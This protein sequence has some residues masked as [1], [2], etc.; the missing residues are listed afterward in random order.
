MNLTTIRTANLIT[1]ELDVSQHYFVRF[2]CLSGIAEPPRPTLEACL[3]ASETSQTETAPDIWRQEV[4]NDEFSEC[5]V[6]RRYT[7]Y[8]NLKKRNAKYQYLQEDRKG[9]AS[10]SPCFAFATSNSDS[11]FALPVFRSPLA[12][13]IGALKVVLW[14]NF[15]QLFKKELAWYQRQG[16]RFQWIAFYVEIPTELPASCNGKYSPSSNTQ[17]HLPF[18]FRYAKSN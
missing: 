13:L 17:I 18:F 7:Y 16:Y 8:K 1:I 5:G 6:E 14:G 11:P 4:I 15:Q 12:Y 10:G 2:V 3:L 9:H